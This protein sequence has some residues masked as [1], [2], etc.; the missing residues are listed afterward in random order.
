M[1]AGNDAAISSGSCCDRSSVS[2]NTCT[3][4]KL[5]LTING[6]ASASNSQ[7]PP[8]RAK[9]FGAAIATGVRL[10]AMISAGSTV[11]LL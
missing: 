4:M 7:L 3:V 9:G 1:T 5:W 8:A 10:D 11:S 2:T 6:A